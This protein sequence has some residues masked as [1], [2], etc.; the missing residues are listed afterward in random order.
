VECATILLVSNFSIV[1]HAV[2]HW[3]ALLWHER[4]PD[5]STLTPRVT[6]RDD[7]GGV[8]VNRRGVYKVMENEG[9]APLT[10]VVDIAILCRRF[11]GT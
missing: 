2:K 4:R 3:C 10:T 1:S 8:R 5:P 7:R 9:I 6:H 11:V